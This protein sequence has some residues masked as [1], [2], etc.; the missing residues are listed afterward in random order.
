MPN[1]FDLMNPSRTRNITTVR[2][3]RIKRE[4][5]QYYTWKPGVIATT[6]S[7][8][9]FPD[10]HFPDSKKYS[11]LDWIEVVNNEPTNDLTLTINSTDSFKVPAKTIRTIDNIALRHIKVTNDGGGNTTAGLIVITLQKQPMTIDKWSRRQ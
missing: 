7:S 6:A 11:P 9:I 5:S 10:I 2:Q 1:I 8:S 3:E 4:G